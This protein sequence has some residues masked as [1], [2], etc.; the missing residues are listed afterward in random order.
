MDAVFKSVQLFEVGEGLGVIVNY[1]EEGKYRLAIYNNTLES[2]PFS[3]RSKIGRIKSI[4]ELSTGDKLFQAQGYWPNGIRG[5]MNGKDNDSYIF[6]GDIRLFDVSV[7]EERVE[8]AEKIQQAKSVSRRLLVFDDILFTKETIRYMPT[9]FD[10][11]S[12]ISV[13]GD[14]LLQADSYAL[15]EQ[16]KWFCLQKLQITAD[17]RKGFA[18]GRWTFDRVCHSISKP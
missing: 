18:S 4:D 13:E 6:G 15:K 9:F 10:Y 14:K 11:F 2:L 16:N 17:L 7:D 1:L 12:G 3:I 8:L 5:D